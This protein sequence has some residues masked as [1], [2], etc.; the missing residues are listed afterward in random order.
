MK[1]K[2]IS[3]RIRSF[4]YAFQGILDFVGT[5]PNARLHLLAAVAAVALGWG[6]AISRAE[7]GLIILCIVVVLAA[8]AFNTAVETLT[9]L[10]SPDRHPLARR[11][12]DVAAG[13][14][15]LTALGALGCGLLVFLP[16]IWPILFR[17]WQ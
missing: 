12:K 1:K 16:K 3:G 5:E 15:L 8:E 7:W 11:A 10:V 2:W 4:K 9:D 17:I 14:V 6:L 13:A